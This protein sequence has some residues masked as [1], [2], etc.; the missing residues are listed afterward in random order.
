[1][2]SSR[3]SIHRWSLLAATTAFVTVAALAGSGVAAADTTRP[4][5]TVKVPSPGQVF[6]TS[7]VTLSG[8]ATDNVGVAAVDVAIKDRSTG[9]WLRADG[10]WGA[11][12]WLRGRLGA[13]G[14]TWTRWT[15]P[16]AAPTGLF[17]ATV[18]AR[19][20]AG[21]ADAT[22]P[23]VRFDV[24]L[25]PT[26]ASGPDVVLILTDDQRADTLSAMPNVRSLLGDRGVTFTNGFVANALCCPS[27]ANILK[28]AYSHS[29]RVYQNGGT[30]G[31][32]SS[33]DDRSTM[34][35]WL[36]GGGYRT[37]FVGKYFNGY[38]PSRASYVPPGWDRWVAFATTDIGGGRYLDYGLSIDGTYRTYGSATAD[39][40]TDVL[41]TFAESF[42]RG[43]PADTPLFL[44]FAPYA[45]HEPA[46]PAP[47]H[48]TMF[49][50]LPTHR[51]PSFGEVDVSDKPAYIRSVPTF[52]QGNI[53]R[54]DSIRRK[55]YQ[56][57]LAVDEA[58]ARIV[59][60]LQD[61]GRLAT[62]MIVFTSDNG[63]LWGEHRWGTTGQMNKQVPYEESIRVPFV[64]RYD[65][66]VTTPRVDPDLVLNI[67]IAP[68]FAALAGVSAPGAEGSSMLPLLA[69]PTAAW[70]SD[71]LIEHHVTNVPSYCAV[72]NQTTL[73]V[74][75]GTGEQE[76]YLLDTDPFQ[77]MNR[78]N[79][80]AYAQTV[81][82]M[83]ARA[84]SLCSPPP[85]GYSFTSTTSIAQVQH[86]STK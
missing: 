71:F 36:D 74:R 34:A 22:R 3:R 72:R 13:P 32:M 64:V 14:A 49:G 75:Y 81:S 27:R 85:P 78:A 15:F 7:P 6:T 63:F 57:L 9:R 67:D 77:L 44:E 31:P 2:A 43:T 51:P 76:L 33:F 46:T 45:P 82:A 73:Y 84:Q 25:T 52:R 86:V 39:Y 40:S 48:A 53:D 61:T 24:N 68:T 4:D 35:T 55:Q 5:A 37:A 29:T 47:R 41:A 26:P 69:S 18:R 38:D 11:F 70:R 10:T 17:A 1:M 19:D 8:T 83:R 42:I 50:N 65:P 58:V 79:D 56:S 66:L 62:T 21:N 16:F 20:A 28:G 59:Q 12:V 54:I 80:P 23:W 30:Y 60:A